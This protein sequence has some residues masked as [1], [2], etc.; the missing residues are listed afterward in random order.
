M[1]SN[2]STP[3]QEATRYT[4][5]KAGPYF[6]MALKMESEKTA[7]LF[8]R[9]DGTTNIRTSGSSSEI[10]DFK[11]FA[12]G[13]TLLVG[14][15]T[16]LPEGRHIPFTVETLRW[17]A[18]CPKPAAVASM[19]LLCGLVPRS[20]NLAFV[21]ES[22]D[23]KKQGQGQYVRIYD[24]MTLSTTCLPTKPGLGAVSQGDPVRVTYATLAPGA[25]QP[26]TGDYTIPHD[27]PYPKG[28]I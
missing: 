25:L 4:I 9:I 17:T 27:A 13:D 2:A 22:L 20:K 11:K 19:A 15:V 16:S 23:S 5:I 12:V 14:F 8:L 24:P 26:P 3:L 6:S 18:Q 7:P 1:A 28:K 10:H 21:A